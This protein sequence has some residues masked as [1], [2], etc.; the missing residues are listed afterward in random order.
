MNINN[1]ADTYTIFEN[2]WITRI[3]PS[4]NHA[5][6]E[7]ILLLL[8]GWTGDEHSMWVFTSKLPEDYWLIAFRA[9]IKTPLGGYGWVNPIPGVWPKLSEFK[10]RVDEVFN[11]LNFLNKYL[12]ISPKEVDLMG[13]S[14]GGAMAYSFALLYPQLVQKAAILSGFLPIVDL[15]ISEENYADNNQ[16]LIT[17]GKMDEIIPVDKAREAADYLNQL[18]VS[19]KYCEEENIGHKISAT[20]HRTVQQFFT[21]RS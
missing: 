4:L 3:R 15:P 19:T 7:K 12:S 8:H 17:H 2:G 16:F 13:F 18:G 21:L 9:P 5:K 6:P 1:A 10:N 11:H 20:C 14:Q